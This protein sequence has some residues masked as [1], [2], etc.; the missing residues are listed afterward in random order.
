MI[1]LFVNEIS[2]EIGYPIYII[3]DFDKIPHMIIIG[4][5]G[6]GKSYFLKLLLGR[7]SKYEKESQVFICDFKGDTDL[8][9]L[10]STKNFYRYLDCKKGLEEFYK[11]FQARQ[12]GSDL[13]RHPVFLAFD[14][15]ASYINSFPSKKE[16]DEA[17]QIL[18]NLLMLGRSFNVHIIISQQRA[19]A[20][21]FNTARDNFGIVIGLGNLSEESKKMFFNDYKDEIESDRR[22]G[23]GYVLENGMNLQKIVVPKISDMKKLEDAIKEVVNR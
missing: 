16:M 21:Y 8:I 2:L 22:I 23:T 4:G 20:Q 13:Q 5:T 12:S 17:K 7:L 10:E 11:L 18:S 15:W 14:E 9:F 6:S 19:D 1:K 3:W